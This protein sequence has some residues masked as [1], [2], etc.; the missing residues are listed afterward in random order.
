MHSMDIAFNECTMAA[1][2]AA[3]ENEEPACTML[4]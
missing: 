4:D 3:P 1:Q 2:N